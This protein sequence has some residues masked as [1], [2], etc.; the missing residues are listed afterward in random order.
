MLDF[1]KKNLG[2]IAFGIASV[3]VSCLLLVGILKAVK[4]GSEYRKEVAEQYD[5]LERAKNK[6]TALTGENLDVARANH[7][8]ARS[9]FL[10]LRKLLW[11]KFSIPLEQ[12]TDVQCVRILK[13]ECQRMHKALEEKEVAIGGNSAYFSFDAEATTLPPRS[14]VPIILK[15]LRI[16]HEIVRLVGAS[17]LTELRTVERTA[18][19][20]IDQRDM[21]SIV[22]FEISVVGEFKR[23]QGFVNQLQRESRYLFFVRELSL[24]S[25]DQAEGGNIPM[26]AA[27]KSQDGGGQRGGGEGMMMG[28]GGMG[29]DGGGMGMDGAAGEDMMRAGMMDGQGMGGRGAMVPGAAGRMARQGRQGRQQPQQESP[30]KVEKQLSTTTR[31]E[32]AVFQPHLLQASIRLDFV[33]FHEPTEEN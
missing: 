6:G 8:L 16:I 4:S 13:T 11:T 17:Y 15:Q 2:L 26:I 9:K 1:L 22:P 18:K 29:M 19:T 33:E 28:G 32:R 30:E 7:A 3:V 25:D 21:Y 27:T 12:R 31:E 10:E 24:Q 14:Q 20:S 23:I 5:F